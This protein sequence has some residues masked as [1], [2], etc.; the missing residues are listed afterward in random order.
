VVA[1]TLD[2]LPADPGYGWQVHDDESL[3]PDLFDAMQRAWQA[4]VDEALFGC[5]D[6]AAAESGRI[7]DAR[8]DRLG[9]GTESF[10]FRFETQVLVVSDSAALYNDLAPSQLA[11]CAEE[12]LNAIADELLAGLTELVED[13]GTDT[14]EL[15]PRLEFEVEVE[16][17]GFFPE[18]Y[19]D[20]SHVSTLFYAL[21]DGSSADAPNFFDVA[22]LRVDD[23]VGLMEMHGGVLDQQ[24]EIIQDAVDR[25]EAAT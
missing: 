20:D 13:A 22:V 11:S 6:A 24:E 9:Q 2:D 4:R 8:S 5:A 17:T 10:S 21:S 12:E 3:G 16:D 25:A 23:T 19:G 14:D 18:T 1:G 15:P 7:A